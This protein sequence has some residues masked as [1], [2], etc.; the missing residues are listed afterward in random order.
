MIFS[1]FEGFDINSSGS[2]KSG[3]KLRED[4][5]KIFFTKSYTFYGPTQQLIGLENSTLNLFM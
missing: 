2:N 4:E 1:L 3:L 5:I